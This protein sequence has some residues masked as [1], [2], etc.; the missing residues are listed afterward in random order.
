M[1]DI[2]TRQYSSYRIYHGL[3]MHKIKE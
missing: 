3:Q 1:N 2:I